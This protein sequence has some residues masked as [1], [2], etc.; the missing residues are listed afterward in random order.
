MPSYSL[1]DLFAGYELREQLAGDKNKVI[2]VSFNLSVTNVLD[3]KYI[4]DG[5]NGNDFGPSTA[6][7]FMGLGRRWNAGMRFA[8]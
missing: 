7:V 1:L 2:V 8:F 5:Q 6:I 3:T 4:S